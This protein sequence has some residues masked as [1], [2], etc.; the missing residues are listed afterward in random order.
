MTRPTFG[1]PLLSAS[2][3][4]HDFFRA[5]AFSANGFLTIGDP[6]SIL[7]VIFGLLTWTKRGF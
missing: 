3:S 6:A 5:V 4:C 1:S 2:L 7:V